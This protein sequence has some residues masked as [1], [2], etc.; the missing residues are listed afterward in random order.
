M[1]KKKAEK[2]SAPEAGAKTVGCNC[3]RSPSALQTKHVKTLL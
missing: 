3:R 2:K 1:G